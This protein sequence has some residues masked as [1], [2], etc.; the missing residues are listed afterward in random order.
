MHRSGT[1]SKS[2]L[3]TSHTTA[4]R[5]RSPARD[6]ESELTEDQI[7][8]QRRKKRELLLARLADKETAELNDTQAADLNNH[9]K[10]PLNK[11]SNSTSNA[12]GSINTRGE[13][14]NINSWSSLS[15]EDDMFSA[16]LGTTV[17]Q[18]G[19][20]LD[21]SLLDNWDDLEGYY[22]VIAGELI[23]DRYLVTKTLGQGVFAAVVRAE[24]V[25]TRKTVAIKI[26]RNNETMRA[27]GLKEIAML[28]MLNIA[29]PNDDR[30]IVRL[31]GEFEFKN[32]QCLVFENLGSNLREVLKRFGRDTG[33]NIKAVRSY[34]LQTLK[35]L[36]LLRKCEIVHA[37]L[38]P[39]NMLVDESHKLLKIADLGSASLISEGADP[40][41]YL[42]S[43]FYR[44]PELILG[45]AHE[46]GIDMW[47]LGCSIYE[48]YT[49]KILF[50]GRTNNHMLKIIMECRGKFSHKMLRRGKFTHQHFNNQL[51]F[52]SR[53]IDKFT[54]REVEKVVKNVGPF[55]DK[56]LKGL[57]NEVATASEDRLVLDKFVDLLDKMLTLNPEKRITPQE[58]LRH[59]FLTNDGR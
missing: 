45:V 58:A 49:G 9:S 43:R 6:E 18:Q 29:D 56:T 52:V 31:L 35:G 11:C 14:N 24:D 46:Y 41:P 38:K 30:H 54:E 39:D 32:H 57:L 37:D 1:R 23:Y 59:P 4:I 7:I 47:S 51:D 33:I 10:S 17:D 15:S 19:K 2:P 50:S 21:Q 36:D 48:L 13:N 3:G 40:T 16:N 22:R 8:E 55:P 12:N 28:N 44:A 53:E 27:A 5:S 26:I 34:T 25:T 20:R 42:V